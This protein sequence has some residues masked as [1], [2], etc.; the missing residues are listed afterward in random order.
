MAATYSVRRYGAG[1]RLGDT[2]VT[3]RDHCSWTKPTT[4]P[5]PAQPAARMWTSPRTGGRTVSPFSSPPR[6]LKEADRLA[7]GSRCSTRAACGRAHPLRTQHQYPAAPPAPVTDVRELDA[8]ARV[9]NRLHADDEDLTLWG[10]PG[11]CE[12]KSLGPCDHSMIIRIDVEEFSLHTPDLDAFSWPYRALE[13]DEK[14]QCTTSAPLD[15]IR[16]SCCVANLSTSSGS[17]HVIHRGLNAGNGGKNSESAGLSTVLAD[18]CFPSLSS[19]V[20]FRQ[21]D[22]Q[23]VCGQFLRSN[24]PSRLLSNRCLDC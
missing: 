9:R 21:P 1:A 8:A 2:L 23:G 10:F 14:A 19:A 17:G 3:G 11:D 22:G 4:G 24:S 15:R 12:V 16:G 5:G 20:R 13:H 7:A 18:P 6:N